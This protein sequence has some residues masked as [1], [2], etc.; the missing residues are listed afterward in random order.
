MEGRFKKLKDANNQYVFPITRAEG[1][2]VESNKTLA[3]KLMEI[4]SGTGGNSTVTSASLFSY[5]EPK[6]EP[7][8]ISGNR[9]LR[10]WTVQQF[11]DMYDNLV[12]A[13]PDYIRKE[14]APYKD[15]SGEY[16]LHRYVFE[17]E[18]G[19]D[20]TIYI[21]SGVHGSEYAAKI[22]IARICQLICEEWKSSPHL[23]YLRKRVRIILIPIINPWG[24]TA[25]TLVNSNISANTQGKGVNCNR[26]YD[27]NWTQTIMSAGSD[28]NGGSPMSENETKWVRDT[29]LDYGIENIHYGF[30]CHD[31]PTASIQGDFWINYNTLH[32]T[33]LQVNRPLQWYLADKYVKDR[34]PYL[35][36]DKDTATTGTFSGWAN[37]TLGIP[38]STLEHCYGWTNEVAFESPFMTRAL[39]TFINAIVMNTVADHKAPIF[40]SNKKWFELEWWKAGNT[41]HNY[42]NSQL[43]FES[44]IAPWEELV[45][46]YPKYLKKSDTFFTTSDGKQG[47]QYILE[48]KNY[49]KTIL[50]VGGRGYG[51]TNFLQFS[52]AML[53]FTELMC[54]YGYEDEHLTYLK[55]N[56]RIV[57]VPMLEYATVYL[58]ASGNFDTNGVPNTTRAPVANI[59]N[60][61]EGLN[62]SLNGVIYS[63]ELNHTNQLAS[64]L[65]DSFKLAIQDTNDTVNIDSYVD[66]LNNKG[67]VSAYENTLSA[68]FA[69]YVVNQKQLPCV[70][71]D[72]GLDHKLYEKKKTEYAT[73]TANSEISVADFSKF[74]SETARRVTHIVNVVKLMSEA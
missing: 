5:Y 43:S 29:L 8:A 52:I 16:D 60:V 62:S 20:K 61:I 55:D 40:K 12:A 65:D 74:N 44:I 53:R 18:D 33:S 17:P 45:L 36:H 63:Q 38:A 42:A 70:R 35:W 14:T 54:I 22:T 21:G 10:S 7:S 51:N 30:D 39:D 67:I 72:S 49:K 41:S 56:V 9:V 13:Y 64:T 66:H 31:A 11:Y 32:T 34:E 73:Q 2:F 47:Y 25:N 58:N 28:H 68:E 4:G 48:P 27:M 37:K 3:Q 50:I 69:N 59:V 46:K 26:N 1:V 23:E 24:H 15:M 19:Y 57:F 71:I 6:P